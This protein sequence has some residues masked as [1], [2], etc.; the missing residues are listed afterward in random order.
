MSWVRLDDGYPEHPKVDRVGPL[1]AWLN[2]CAWAY[3]ARNLTDGFV[4]AERVAR[5]ASVPN[6]MKL[7][8]ALV[9]VKLWE[10]V[11]GGYMVHDFLDYNPSRE[12]VLTERT[13]NAR[14]AH[15]WRSQQRTNGVS[16]GVTNGVRTG[17]PAR[18]VPGDVIPGPDNPPTADAVGPPTATTFNEEDQ[19]VIDSVCEVLSPFKFSLAPGHWRKV[20]D[21]YGGVDL[22]AEAYKQADWLRRHQVKSCSASRYTNW[23]A[24]AKSEKVARAP[25]DFEDGVGEFDWG[26]WCEQVRADMAANPR[27]PNVCPTHGLIEVSA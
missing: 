16:N 22:E 3:C 21:D 20:L 8:A 17:A 14:R 25:T 10:R 7:A 15:E 5:L 26:C 23:L 13:N 1:A 4:P 27:A 11:D 12:Q 19:R 18:P 9:Q 6:P 2:V 24:K